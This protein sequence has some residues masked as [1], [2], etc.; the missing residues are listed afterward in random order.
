MLDRT[1]APIFFITF[2]SIEAEYAGFSIHESRAVAGAASSANISPPA[3]G[4]HD[5]RSQASRRFP[6][7][8]LPKS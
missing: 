7:N 5:A 3:V 1:A 4:R 2:A 8:R 6:I